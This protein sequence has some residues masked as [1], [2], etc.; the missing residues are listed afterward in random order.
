M[1]GCF[2]HFST[3]G[4]AAA[5]S[6]CSDSSKCFYSAALRMA[7]QHHWRGTEWNA[8]SLPPLSPSP[9]FFGPLLSV[10]P[11]LNCFPN[12]LTSTISPISV[13]LLSVCPS[14]KAHIQS[15]QEVSAVLAKQASICSVHLC[16]L[17]LWR[18]R[19]VTTNWCKGEP[20]GIWISPL[21]ATTRIRS[22]ANMYALKHWLLFFFRSFRTF[23]EEARPVSTRELALC[24]QG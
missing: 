15:V 21:L 6:C 11:H 5:G 3:T 24:G 1:Q 14:M 20:K 22:V 18:S 4:V 10:F 8:V 23:P 2:P 19:G 13:T 9:S 17:H 12:A 16:C 7:L